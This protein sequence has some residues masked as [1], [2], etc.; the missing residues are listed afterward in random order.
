MEEFNTKLNNKFAFWYRIA[1]D[2]LLNQK[3]LNKDEYEDTVKIISEFDNIETF[4]KIFQ[5]MK[6]PSDLNSGIEFQLFKD[7]IKPI[8]EDDNNKHGGK[9][10]IKIK[11]EY[12]SL[13]WEELVLGF[14]GA[15]LT[16][17]SKEEINGIVLSV[18]RDFNLIQIWFRTYTQGV[19]D[20]LV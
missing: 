17:K 16:Q 2:T 6:K 9:I 13:V 19:I 11:K 18:K 8:W 14:I 5:H 15:N 10:T 7:N 4:W 12:S 20:E 1:D 3:H